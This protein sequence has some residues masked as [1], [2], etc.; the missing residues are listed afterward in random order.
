MIQT[1]PLLDLINLESSL[2][3]FP[4]V[5][6]LFARALKGPSGGITAAADVNIWK[7]YLHY[8]RRQ[9]P[10]GAGG[11]EDEG[12]RRVITEAYE[13]ALKQCGVDRE[14]GDIWQEYI[15]FVQDN[16]VGLAFG[17]SDCVPLMLLAQEH[18]GNTGSAGYRAEDIST[19]GMY[20]LEQ[21]RSAV[22]GIRCVRRECK[23]ADRERSAM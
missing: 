19:R 9:N 5:E 15:A 13:F 12:K 6:N 8:I 7:A 3:N 20:T 11:A 21:C 2:N 14:A 10:V 16:K 17:I 23:Q 22:E 1:Q 4:A 18:L